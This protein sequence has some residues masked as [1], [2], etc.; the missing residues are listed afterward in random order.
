MREIYKSDFIVS[1]IKYEENKLLSFQKSRDITTSYRVHE[2]GKVGIYCQVGEISEEE[3]FA[4]AR[5]N[6]SERARPYPFE[7]E[8][9]KRSRDKTERQVSDKELMEIAKDCMDYICE[10]YPRFTF[11]AGFSQSRRVDYCINDKGMD[12]SNTDCAVSV[13][14][15]FKH[16]DSKDISDGGFSFSLRDFDRKVFYKMADDYLANYEKEVELPED[17]IIDMQY[18]NLLGMLSGC[19]NGENVALGTSLLTGKIGEKVFSEDFTLLNDV[20]DEECWYDPFWDGDGCVTENDKRILIDKGVVL[21]AYADKKTAKK[22]DIPHTGNAYADYA[23]IPGPGVANLRIVRSNKTIKELLN[24]R[25]CVIPVSYNGGG[26]A[27]NGDYTMP[28]Q[29]AM[30]SDG[31][32]ILGKLPPFTMVSNMFDMFGK[33]FIGVGADNPIFNDKQ[34]LFRVKRGNIL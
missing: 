18:Y 5:E 8:T 11:S 21:T 1:S 16:V 29:C 7:L 24:G 31:E 2:D 25:Y 26:F 23:D 15:G 17:I 14:I 33:D 22:Y 19:L 9:G 32:R 30:L 4:K 20:S 10:K 12:Y 13:D 28:I 27:D 6:L 3:G 34:I